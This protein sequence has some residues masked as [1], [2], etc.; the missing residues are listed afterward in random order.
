VLWL[1]VDPTQQVV[2]DELPVV[3]AQPAAA[4]A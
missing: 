2:E 1:R 4:V 3:S